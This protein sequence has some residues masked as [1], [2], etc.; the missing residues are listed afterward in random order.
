MMR[1]VYLC[2]RPDFY[3]ESMAAQPGLRP[4]ILEDLKLLK[5]GVV[6]RPTEKCAVEIFIPGVRKGAR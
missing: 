5:C 6:H 3:I 2:A 1:L 4:T